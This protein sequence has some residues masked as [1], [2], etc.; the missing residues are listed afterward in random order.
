MTNRTRIIRSPCLLTSTTPSLRLL[1]IKMP[2][3]FLPEVV[4]VYQSLKPEPSTSFAFWPF[5]LVS[6]TNRIFTRLLIATSTSSLNLPV[7][8]PTFQ[9]PRRILVGSASFLTLRTCR[10]KCEDPCSFF[11]T[12][13]HRC[14]APQRLRRPDPCSLIIVSGSRY[15]AP[16][17]G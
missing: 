13:G 14:S 4:P 2:T 1:S 7:R 9:L 8:D 12:P 5:H 10:E 6:C 11:T 15:N 3:P 17:R 16:L